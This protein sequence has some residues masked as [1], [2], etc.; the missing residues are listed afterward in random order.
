[1]ELNKLIIFDM[2]NTLIHSHLNFP[3][4]KAETVG[5]LKEGRYAPDET[6]PLTQMMNIFRKNE[7]FSAELEARIWRRVE[8]IEYE[9]LMNAGVEPGIERVL[10]ILGKFAHLVVLTNTKEEAARAIL[11][12]LGLSSFL[13]QIMG[14]GGAPE[15]K[16]APGGMLALLALY[17]D[18]AKE[19]AL[20][21]GDALID[22]RA[23]RGAGLRFCAYN[24]SR[25][26]QWQAGG[27]QPDLE[28]KSWDEPATR[29]LLAL[30]EG[31]VACFG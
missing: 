30:L 24:R 1:M 11:L 26:E 5:L 8:E 20:A 16:P 7:R 9:G 15:L 25:A 4:M 18:L 31:E 6:M 27:H 3:L 10:E 28:L 19:D 23:A 14:R 12:Q 17:P 21:V 2:D 13:E 22:I 29:Q